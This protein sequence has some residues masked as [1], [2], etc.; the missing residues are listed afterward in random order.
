MEQCIG[1]RRQ[2]ATQCLWLAMWIHWVALVVLTGFGVAS[3]LVGLVLLRQARTVTS[4]PIADARRSSLWWTRWAI[5]TRSGL[6]LRGL[7]FVAFG[8]LA[9]LNFALLLFQPAAQPLL[10]IAT[11]V[12]WIIL[13][14]A[15]GV[16]Q[17][18]ATNRFRQGR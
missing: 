9:P 2:L 4:D 15:V 8:V 18:L 1:R 6:A 10:A 12:L 7:L 16:E 11:A 17:F 13:T 3:C 14:S 5:L